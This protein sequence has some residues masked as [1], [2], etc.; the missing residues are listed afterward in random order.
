VA[1]GGKRRWH[2]R[3]PLSASLPVRRR[4]E[5]DETEEDRREQ[6]RKGGREPKMKMFCLEMLFF[7]GS[8]D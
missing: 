3:S 4:T 2:G 7:P 8:N 1:E 5:T 6:N